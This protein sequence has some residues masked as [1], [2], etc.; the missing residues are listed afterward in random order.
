MKNPDHDMKGKQKAISK[1]EIH[2]TSQQASNHFKSWGTKKQL[3]TNDHPIPVSPHTVCPPRKRPSW[4]SLLVTK[5]IKNDLDYPTIHLS[6]GVGRCRQ[7]H[8][9]PVKFL[10][11]MQILHQMLEVLRSCGI[12][13]RDSLAGIRMANT[14]RSG[15][16]CYKVRW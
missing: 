6:Y 15:T 7:D 12:H 8:L 13:L 10:V 4:T 1:N 16:T 14:K 5:K 11:Q 9:L 3:T 2:P